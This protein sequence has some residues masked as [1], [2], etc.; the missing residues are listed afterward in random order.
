MGK[1]GNFVA[2][3]ACVAGAVVVVVV[4][5]FSLSRRKE[6]FGGRGRTRGNSSAPATWAIPRAIFTAFP[7]AT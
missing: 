4:V 2:R 7:L 6:K 5:V 3:V 1:L